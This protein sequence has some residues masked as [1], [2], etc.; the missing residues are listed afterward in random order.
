MNTKIKPAVILFGKSKRFII[1]LGVALIIALGNI[2]LRIDHRVS[3]S[4][5]CPLPI[6]FFAWYA[7][8]K[9]VL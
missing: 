5:F 7:D 9:Q 3:F 1:L 2:N 4:I 8:L 6:A